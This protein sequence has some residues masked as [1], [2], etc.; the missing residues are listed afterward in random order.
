MGKVSRPLYKL[1]HDTMRLG[2]MLTGRVR[3]SVRV[4]ITVTV[5]VMV[6]FGNV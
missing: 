3:V 2:V 5:M 1:N 4:R 6:R